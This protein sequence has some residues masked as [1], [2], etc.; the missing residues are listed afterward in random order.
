MVTSTDFSGL[1]NE[2]FWRNFFPVPATNS[3]QLG[4][5]TPDFEL[6]DVVGDRTLK[7]SDYRQSQPVIVA[8]TRIFTEKQ[9]CPLCYPHIIEMKDNYSR[10]RE[11]GAEVLM[12]TS[13][14]REQTQQVIRDL[15]MELPLLCNPAC[16]V[17]QQYEVGQALGAPLPAQF[18]LDRDGRLRYKHLFSFLSSNAGVEKLLEVLEQLK[19]TS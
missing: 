18:V 19:A 14:D 2:R 15:N 11:A 5:T 7:L 13:T 6:P 10:F 16:H 1:I 3:L 4:Q 17:F 8:F 9:Y 12:I